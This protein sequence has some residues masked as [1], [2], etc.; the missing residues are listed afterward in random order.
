LVNS[1][2]ELVTMRRDDC[3]GPFAGVSLTMAELKGL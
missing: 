1:G 2:T 3:G